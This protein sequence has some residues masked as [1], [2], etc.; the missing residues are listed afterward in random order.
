MTLV[1]ALVGALDGAAELHRVHALGVF[2]GQ[3]LACAGLG[4]Q[5][6]PSLYELV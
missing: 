5:G 6:V 2:N 1:D 4:S 3:F